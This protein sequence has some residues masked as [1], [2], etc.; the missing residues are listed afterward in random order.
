[1]DA[2]WTYFLP[3]RSSSLGSLICCSVTEGE[4]DGAGDAGI[5]L[6]SVDR[7][8]SKLSAFLI[9]NIPVSDCEEVSTTG[10]G[11]GSTF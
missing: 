3:K 2:I 7:R 11:V 4:A 10:A 1:M 9:L 6:S 5:T 8:A